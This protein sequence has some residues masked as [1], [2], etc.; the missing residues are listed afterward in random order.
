MPAPHIEENVLDRYAMGTL[1]GESIPKVEEHLL[2]CFFC[3]SRLVQTDEFLAIFRAAATQVELRPV[4]LW[5]RLVNAQRLLWGGSAVVAAGL[6]LLMVP[7]VPEQIKP[8]PAIVLMQSLRG[9]EARTEVARGRPSLLIFDV[10]IM[11]GR[12][13]FDIEVVDT[14]GNEVLKGNGNVKEDH[15]TFSIGRLAPARYWVRVYQRQ[16]ARVLV[17]EY[18]LQAK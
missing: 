18:G 2:D 5:Q 7:G 11:P 14:A 10:P 4:P 13:D 3:Q 8:Q 15:L 17:A 12:R 16:P 1:P 9:P 6:V